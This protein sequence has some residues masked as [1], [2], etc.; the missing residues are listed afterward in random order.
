[1][2]NDSCFTNEINHHDV[3][4]EADFECECGGNTFFIQHSG[5]LHKGIF[6]SVSI[7]K[8]RNQLIIKC[9]CSKCLKEYILFDST[10]DGIRPKGIPINELSSLC[11]KGENEF[12][13]KLKYNF[14]KE[15]Y[16]S[17]QFEMFFLE[18]KTPQSNKYISICEQ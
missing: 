8:R 14:L 17:E 11:I 18:V 7:G 1:M 15:N 16:K 9:S 4:L 6:G 10:K 5:V 13:I 3:A 12:Q 2:R